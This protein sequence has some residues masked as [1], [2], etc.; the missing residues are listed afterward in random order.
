MSE[1]QIVKQSIADK[2]SALAKRITDNPPRECRLRVSPQSFSFNE[3]EFPNMVINHYP[4]HS[5]YYCAVGP[6]RRMFFT[7]P[8]SAPDK[9]ALEEQP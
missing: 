3:E 8:H 9:A 7:I 4:D 6:D 5:F 2:M 1:I